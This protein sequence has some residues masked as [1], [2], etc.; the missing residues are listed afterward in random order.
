MDSHKS[1][2]GLGSQRG[3]RFRKTERLRKRYEFIAI[4]RWGRRIHLT[5]LVVLYRGGSAGR[6]LGIT[7]SK[8]VGRA[9]ERNRLKRLIREI[10]RRD[11]SGLPQEVEFAFVAKRSAAGKSFTVL[12]RQVGELARKLSHGGRR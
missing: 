11:R 6:R 4:Q 8:K 12:R 1:P 5:D 2:L 10:W 7:V 3:E 9:V